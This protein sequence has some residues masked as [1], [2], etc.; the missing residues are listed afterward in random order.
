MNHDKKI[1]LI[2]RGRIFLARVNWLSRLA[3]G[4]AA[5]VRLV[6]GMRR[7]PQ[8][9][10]QVT[11]QGMPVYFRPED[12]QA[13]REVL[14]DLEYDPLSEFLRAEQAP[15][16]IDAGG[17]I[18]TF[19]LWAL[20]VNPGVRVLSVEADP[21]TFQVAEKNA[22]QAA[23]RQADWQVMHAA[24]GAD[25]SSV[26]SLSKT[27][28]SMSHRIDPQGR[29]RVNTVSLPTLLARLLKDRDTLDLLK[30]DV[31]GSEEAFLCSNH[32]ALS[33]VKTVM[34]ELHPDLCD[35]ERVKSVL[36]KHYDWITEI[37]GRVSSKPVLLCRRKM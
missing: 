34:V 6:L 20:S 5:A 19:A 37:T 3:G 18:G 2:Q 7:S 12:E 22:A 32:D 16:V 33:Q 36:E 1:N 35:T 31:E 29:I 17:H 13:L 21:D 15:L 11:F 27:G 23:T 30:V 28:P 4:R 9:T 25:D 10:F 14:V 24:A 8:A 26:V